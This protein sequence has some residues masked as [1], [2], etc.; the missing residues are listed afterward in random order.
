MKDQSKLSSEVGNKK[1][2]KQRPNQ[3]ISSTFGKDINQVPLCLHTYVHVCVCVDI[4]T[5]YIYFEYTL[6]FSFDVI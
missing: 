4:Y 3:K 2:E 6:H 5:L 1:G